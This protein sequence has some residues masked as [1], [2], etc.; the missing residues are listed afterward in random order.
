MGV[1][2]NFKDKLLCVVK[3]VK[4]AMTAKESGW[5]IF[6][7][8]SVFLSSAGLEAKEACPR[9]CFWGRLFRFVACGSVLSCVRLCFSLVGEAS[10]FIGV[11]Q[12]ALSA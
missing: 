11:I 7:Y 8:C 1:Y 10:F 4:K 5:T 2:D 9:S 3:V 6:F 12:M